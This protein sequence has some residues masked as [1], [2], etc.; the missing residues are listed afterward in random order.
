MP[1][2]VGYLS[3]WLWLTLYTVPFPLWD[4]VPLMLMSPIISGILALIALPS[5]NLCGIL[6]PLHGTNVPH[7]LWDTRTHNAI[8]PHP[9]WDTCTPVTTCPSSFVTVTGSDK[10]NANHFCEFLARYKVT[11]TVSLSRLYACTYILLGKKVLVLSRLYSAQKKYGI[12][13]TIV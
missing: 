7:N 9:F 1:F 10:Q 5:P 3:H 6:V 13:S 11:L 12:Y 8:V 2:I 4:L